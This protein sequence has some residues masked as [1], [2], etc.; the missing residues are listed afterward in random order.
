MP[1]GPACRCGARPCS[2]RWCG[3]RGRRWNITVYRRAAS[4][5]WAARSKS[6]GPSSERP[7]SAPRSGKN[8]PIS[9]ARESEGKE[10]NRTGANKEQQET[11]C[12]AGQQLGMAQGNVILVEFIDAC[13][14]VSS[15]WTLWGRNDLG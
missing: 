1:R 7:A 10:G 3:C 15:L 14:H 8:Q 5:S 11:A 6:E 13:E 9:A 12:L 4:S 2:P